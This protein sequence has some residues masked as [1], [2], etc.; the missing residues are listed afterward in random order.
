MTGTLGRLVVA[1]CFVLLVG[2]TVAQD[3]EFTVQAWQI[4]GD[5]PIGERKAQAVLEPFLGPQQGLDGL[6]RAAAALEERI[7]A[8]GHTFYRVVLPPQTV[9]SG[10]VR[11]QVYAFTVGEIVVDGNRFHSEENIRASLPSLVEGESPNAA[12]ISRN[13]ALANLNVSKRS[14]LTFGPGAE[15]GKLDARIEVADRDPDRYYLW[16]NDTGTDETGNYRVGAGFQMANFLE[17]DQYLNGTL[18]TSPS[19]PDQVSQYGL[20]W[21]APLY[22]LNSMVSLF[23]IDSDVDSGTVAEFFDV[24]GTGT[25]IGAAF[26]KILPRVEDY[27]QS[28]TLGVT[29]KYF[30]SDID[31]VG[32]P[33]GV[34]VRSRPASVDY[35][36]EYDGESVDSMFS[37]TAL[38]NLPGGARNDQDTYGA[39]RAGA[40]QDWSAMRLDASVE[41]TLNDWILRG[42]IGGQYAD[43]PL[44][45]GEQFGVGGASSVRGFNEREF[46]ADRGVNATFEVLAPALNNGLRVGWFLDGGSLENEAPVAGEIDNLDV[47]STGFTANWRYRNHWIFDMD[48]AHVVSMSGFAPDGSTQ[49]GDER[50]HFNVTYFSE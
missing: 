4:E 40:D 19:K 23:G 32:Q 28:L 16:A 21:R 5:N 12:K 34:D 33:I 35:R 2:T 10:T 15:R 3:I 9:Q 22:R 8:E 18:S 47:V 29:D 37:V 11:L 20:S 43:E 26:S 45:A 48:I 39:A 27:R 41:K 7:Q 24:R 38:W 17:R 14:R 1:A 6:Q 36:G 50:V 30:D 46:T 31:F 44:I 13:L 42:S 25:V 49:E